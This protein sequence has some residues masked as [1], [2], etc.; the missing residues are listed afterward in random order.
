MNIAFA[1]F[2]HYH[3]LG[4][5]NAAVANPEVNLIACFEENEDVREDLRKSHNVDFNASSFEELL[6][7]SN[8]DVIAIGDYYGRR[9]ELAVK[10][11]SAGKH[12][13]ADKPI[14]T[15]LEEL[16]EI[17]RIST[18]K[19]LKV[20]CMLDLRYLAQFNKAKELVENGVIG[21]VKTVS[22]TAQH[23]LNYGVRPMW[24]FEE[25]KHGG[26]INDIGIHGV[27]VIRYITGKNLTHVDYAK[28]WN[29]HA[30]EKTA[31]HDAGQF[32]VTLDGMSVMA[33]VSYAAPKFSGTLPTYWEFTF[34]G[35]DGMMRFNLETSDVA[36]Y[37][38]DKAVYKSELAKTPDECYYDILADFCLE[39]KGE[40]T[41]LS[42][43]E[44]LE[45]Q[46]Q[47]LEIQRVAS[48]K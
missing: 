13:I 44:C 10:A 23:H 2:R 31:F 43:N 42:T 17:K 18:E 33:D 19:G 8:I 6:S 3:I 21:E 27:D 7:N 25:G 35:L 38:T 37:K 32:A 22:F 16:D 26:T 48:Q 9:G 29:S 40:N 4:L 46:R 5:Y 15:S 47:I 28:T 34:W 30:I 41:K 45:S 11:L 12:V 14:C 39:V 36:V 24:Y 20:G 1:G